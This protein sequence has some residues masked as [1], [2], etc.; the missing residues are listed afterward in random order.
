MSRVLVVAGPVPDG[1]VW[2][3]EVPTEGLPEWWRCR[4]C[5][6]RL[7]LTAGDLD[8]WSMRGE[9]RHYAH[10]C[11][12]RMW[13]DGPFPVTVA[14]WQ[15]WRQCRYCG[16]E[17]EADGDGFVAD[18]FME[19]AAS[20]ESCAMEPVGAVVATVQVLGPSHGGGQCN[21][22]CFPGAD[23][24]AGWHTPVG[25]VRWL[26]VPYPM[27]Q[28]TEHVARLAEHQ[29]NERTHPY[30]CGNRSDGNHRWTHDK[31][32]LVPTNDGWVC[33]DCDYTQPYFE[34]PASGP[35]SFWWAV[36][37]AEVTT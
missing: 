24:D 32:V 6:V 25:E 35:A 30:T 15:E 2:N 3:V 37:P 34:V 23:P 10:G 5:S 21:G 12:G 9:V 17:A 22:Y 31:G 16:T 1:P 19:C 14:V 13:K 28:P 33:L 8:A 26:D 20:G 27:E 4:S 11:Y 36:L 18:A 29:A 7:R